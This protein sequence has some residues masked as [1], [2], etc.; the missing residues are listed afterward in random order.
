VVCKRVG[1]LEVWNLLDDDGAC[2]EGNSIDI[3]DTK[4]ELRRDCFRGLA[5]YLKR[6]ASP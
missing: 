1:G 2:V 6:N 5:D 3:P 4:I